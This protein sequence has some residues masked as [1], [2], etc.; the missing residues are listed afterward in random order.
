MR[1]SMSF[2]ILKFFNNLKNGDV[3]CVIYFVKL[4]DVIESWYC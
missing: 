4:F 3:Y 1:C 2:I